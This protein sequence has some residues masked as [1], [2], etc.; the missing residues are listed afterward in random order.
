MP[1]KIGALV[2]IRDAWKKK[3]RN[4]PFINAPTFIPEA[5]QKYADEIIMEPTELDPEE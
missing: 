4:E 3:E 5:N 1:G 2:K